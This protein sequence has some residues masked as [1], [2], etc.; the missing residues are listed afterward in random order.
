M[1]K[2][3]LMKSISKPFDGHYL[4]LRKKSIVEPQGGPCSGSG[5]SIK[6]NHIPRFKPLGSLLGLLLMLVMHNAIARSLGP[7]TDFW[8][9][10]GGG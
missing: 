5:E 8:R 2:S 7:K 1:D 9:T 3:L 4:I 10:N 6:A